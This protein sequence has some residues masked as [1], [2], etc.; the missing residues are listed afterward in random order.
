MK[1]S[2]VKIKNFRGYGV[3]HK[4][5]DGYFTFSDLDKC[6]FLILNGYNGFGKTSFF[7]AIEW[8]LTNSVKRLKSFEDND[9]KT[10]LSS[11][12]YLIFIPENKEKRTA[13]VEIKFS[14]GKKIRRTTASESL[15]ASDYILKTELYFDDKKKPIN[16]D[17]FYH[18]SLKKIFTVNFLGQETILDLLKKDKPTER[19]ESFLNLI[20]LSE[21]NKIEAA[22]KQTFAFNPK[23]KQKEKELKNLQE[24][25]KKVDTL[26][27]QKS[28]DSY[29]SYVN[30]V[31][32]V[33]AL[34]SNKIEQLKREKSKSW[35]K[36]Y[37][38]DEDI[39]TENCY[40]FIDNINLNL[41]RVE[42]KST[43]TARQM[44]N[45][46]DFEGCEE[47]IL[48]FNRNNKIDFIKDF[49]F[50]N[51]LFILSG[52]NR[53]IKRYEAENKQ[54]NKIKDQI[55]LYDNLIEEYLIT[56]LNEVV[57]LKDCKIDVTEFTFVKEKL[58]EIHSIIKLHSQQHNISNGGLKFEQ[59][60]EIKIKVDSIDILK[61]EQ[62]LQ[63]FKRK[64]DTFN[65]LHTEKG[66]RLKELSTLNS[67]YVNLL[68]DVKQYI[69]GVH[70]LKECPICLNEDLSEGLRKTSVELPKNISLKEQLKNIIKGKV[71]SGNESVT[72]LQKEFDDEQEKFS[73]L[74][75]KIKARFKEEYH[76]KLEDLNK[77]IKEYLERLLSS[78]NLSSKL[79]D[80]SIKVATIRQTSLFQKIDLYKKYYVEIFDEE[81]PVSGK[82]KSIN[83]TLTNDNKATIEKIKTRINGDQERVQTLE[84]FIA[85]RD[86]LKPKLTTKSIN[87]LREKVEDAEQT[88][89]IFKMFDDFVLSKADQQLIKT[90]LDFD[91]KVKKIRKQQTKINNDSKIVSAIKNNAS[92]LK[93]DILDKLYRNKLINHI[94]E[95]INPHFRFNKMNLTKEE[96]RKQVHSNIIHDGIYLN[97]IFS[98]A[99]L[100][101][102]SLSIFLG[103]GLPEKG[104][105]FEQ[106]FLDDPIQSMDD[107]NIL[108]LIDVFREL[109]DI[110][111]V[112][113]LVLSTHDDNFA[114][115][116]RVKMRNKN[117]KVIDFESYGNEGPVI[118]IN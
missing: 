7:E 29:K 23:N 84:E 115:L 102:I 72:K 96:V 101:I 91:K 28:W 68:N 41:S 65:K 88:I 52:Y 22:A 44:K 110:P 95:E 14:N 21:L 118:S 11:N 103:M 117:I 12:R 61:L 59:F 113:R 16:D 47:A 51:R 27:Q 81:F 79:N 97:Q 83:E 77:E 63:D 85:L 1:I 13:D 46:E 55:K 107:L 98:S 36:K 15:Q 99:Q 75:K 86:E 39:T 58:N 82:R 106:L 18:Q 71:S 8:C 24:D 92:K 70:N 57:V 34:A 89:E 31:N 3:N 108:A 17:S 66:K 69:D 20:D 32:K 35:I 10:N 104:S 80:R 9:T 112:K 33:K 45:K 43:T 40:D 62:L 67:D 87:E 5:A 49:Q 50:D 109:V 60:E 26:F 53:Y 42:E 90:T 37:I 76:S 2:T 116:L 48:L 73:N 74:E 4:S 94:Y 6:D 64:K 78:I 54:L 114:K 100:N 93:S 30:N 56:H 25:K 19:S 111:N 105:N 38:P